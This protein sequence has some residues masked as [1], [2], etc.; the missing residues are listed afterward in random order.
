VSGHGRQRISVPATQ[1]AVQPAQEDI[2]AFAPPRFGETITA[3]ASTLEDRTVGRRRYEVV[4]SGWRFE[5]TTEPVQRAELRDRALRAAAEHGLRADVT[6]RAQIPGRVARVWVEEGE[7]VEE[8]QRLIAIEA[9]K[10]ENEIRA[11]HAGIVRSIRV[12]PGAKI[13]RDAE[14]L[15]VAHGE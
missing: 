14:L 15:T 3:L 4:V 6:L 11:P 8:G 13:E 9:M 12:A 2:E 10:M 7:R 5:V 1:L